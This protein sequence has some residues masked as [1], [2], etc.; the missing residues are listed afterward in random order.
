[1]PATSGGTIK[2]QGQLDG[3]FM[4]RWADMCLQSL[5][6]FMTTDAGPFISAISAR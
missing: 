6:L 5:E 2:A 4:A 3:K 1:M